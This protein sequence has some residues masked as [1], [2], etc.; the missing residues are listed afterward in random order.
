[1]VGPSSNLTF[2]Y[3]GQGDRLRSYDA[4]SGTPTL[5][6]Y[7][8]DLEA[9]MSDL[10]SD[11]S[12]DY[13]YLNPGSGQ[14]PLAGYTLSTQ[15]STTLGT[16]LLGSVR[17]VTDPTGAT[18]GAGAY[19]A[20]GDARPN[21]DTSTGSGATLLAGLLGSQPFGFAG[22]YYDAAAGTYGMRAREYS[23]SEGQFESVD[24]LLDQTG[25]PYQYAGDDP[26][27]TTDPSGQDAN[28]QY[29]TAKIASLDGYYEADPYSSNMFRD[30]VKA[31]FIAR[32]PAVNF[33]DVTD[34]SGSSAGSADLISF[35]T[36]YT[37]VNGDP[38]A[39]IYDVVPDL[40]VTQGTGGIV[41]C[42]AVGLE[43]H[44]GVSCMWQSQLK[45][46][47]TLLQDAALTPQLQY[48]GND[49]AE[50]RH[51][52]YNPCF[53]RSVSL[54]LGT[55]FPFSMRAAL[56]NPGD[57]YGYYH[58]NSGGSTAVLT[59]PVDGQNYLVFP[60]LMAPGLIGFSVCSHDS[61]HSSARPCADPSINYPYTLQPTCPFTGLETAVCG[62]DMFLGSGFTGYFQCTNQACRDAAL[63]SVGGY[64]LVG[65]LS[66]P[67]ARE[68]LGTAA[69]GAGD[70]FRV[71]I[72]GPEA[73]VASQAAL[74]HAIETIETVAS[75]P[76]Q[77]YVRIVF[78]GKVAAT[79]WSQAANIV[80]NIAVLGS[81][82]TGVE[83]DLLLDG[84]AIGRYDSLGN[85]L[86]GTGFQ[87]NHLNQDAAFSQRAAGYS[88]PIIPSKQ[89][90]AASLYGDAFRE[91]GSPH[92]L[93][94]QSLEY[95]WDQYRRGSA[96]FNERPTNATY[97]EALRDAL[98]ASG[99]SEADATALAAAARANRY[100]F[101]LKD[102]MLVPN[103]PRKIYQGAGD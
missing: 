14:A 78:G 92:Y 7:A 47:A 63:S 103:V 15:R 68:V 69:A 97:G 52:Q 35:G 93:F 8:Q 17:V 39:E 16:D 1:M 50:G 26:V 4:S 85:R 28:I 25:Q 10:V 77:T 30:R 89:G 36:P 61:A 21:P 94:H 59:Q 48:F 102:D 2:V 79:S 67:A 60:R 20:W 12:A 29:G 101:G 100:A 23:P 64:A 70:L 98:L 55:D 24:P 44:A 87:A 57:V 72:P 95:F 13:A 62:L 88:G 49:T 32:N 5:S 71:V 76:G 45:N 6:N 82:G 51:T 18:I 37:D 86:S 11:G 91:P 43:T 84:Y 46:L 33:R 83:E 34:L 73:T 56:A 40:L 58:E 38:V 75:R 22:Q 53:A 54:D 19:D 96:L 3:D 99:A 65:T 9:G 27:R 80:K 66:G 74:E 41:G 31:W 81:S 42:G 90:L